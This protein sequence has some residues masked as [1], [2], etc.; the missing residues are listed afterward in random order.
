YI[1]DARGAERHPVAELVAPLARRQAGHLL[2]DEVPT[3]QQHRGYWRL[4]RIIAPVDQNLV[5]GPTDEG[6]RIVERVGKGAVRLRVDPR[7]VDEDRLVDRQRM[8]IDQALDRR[9]AAAVVPAPR[10][11][12]RA[13]QGDRDGHGPNDIAGDRLGA[14][15]GRINVLDHQ[16][17]IARQGPAWPVRR[18]RFACRAPSTL[19]PSWRRDRL[20]RRALL[21][22]YEK[23]RGCSSVGRATD[24]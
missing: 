21:V 4:V 17:R 14:G 12:A 23:Q 16:P 3:G 9:Q 5:F 8:M 11:I 24:F 15:W 20:C 13:D 18:P 6:R 19:S 2:P 22:T 1:R 7:H 10:V